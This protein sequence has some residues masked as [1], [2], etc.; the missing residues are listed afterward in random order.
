S[1]KTIS[2]RNNVINTGDYTVI[3]D[4]YNANPTSTKAS[5]D[6]IMNFKNPRKVCILGDMKELGK[7]EIALHKEV[8]KHAEKCGVDILLTVGD[9]A[10]EMQSQLSNTNGYHFESNE[11]LI[12]SLPKILEKGDAVLIKASHSMHFEEIVKAVTQ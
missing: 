2:G 12:S 10:K 3:D 7:E 9:L 6:T 1:Y 4:C 8:G 11:E 5:I